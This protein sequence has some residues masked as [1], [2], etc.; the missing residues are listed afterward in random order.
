MKIPPNIAQYSKEVTIHMLPPLKC[1]RLVPVRSSRLPFKIHEVCFRVSLPCIN[2]G[3]RI[4][5]TIFKIAATKLNTQPETRYLRI[6]HVKIEYSN[7]KNYTS[8]SSKKN[9]KNKKMSK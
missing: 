2:I 1:I 7:W 8:Q 6:L 5:L 3:V 4:E 9:T